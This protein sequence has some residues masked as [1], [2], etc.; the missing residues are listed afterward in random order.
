MTEFRTFRNDDP[1]QILRLWHES[2]LDRGAAANFNTDAFEELIY[3][4]SY[5]D[6]K[7]L[8]LACD[9]KKKVIGFI[10]AGFGP[11]EDSSKLSYDV[12]IVCA[13]IVHPAYRNQGIG[14]ELLH[15]GIEYLKQS[16]TKT[17]LAGPAKPYDP[18]YHGLYGGARPS[19]F[20]ESDRLSALF[21]ESQG[22]EVFS[23]I[24]IYQRDLENSQDPISARLQS[25]RRKMVMQVTEEPDEPNWWWMTRMGRFRTCRFHLV[26]K[27]QDE[28]VGHLTVYEMVFYP[29]KWQHRAIGLLNLF[30]KEEE[31]RKGYGQTL[32]VDVCRHLRQEM[33]T[34]AEI[35]AHEENVAACKTIESAGFQHVDTG[36][37]YRRVHSV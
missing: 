4:Q 21:F 24:R 36:I 20:L 1:P 14:K 29:S 9:E 31:R 17:V 5:F 27:N 22:F 33:I 13:L 2:G 25:I 28:S 19:G 15:R 18:F 35:H 7:G 37:V 3:C 32:L 16:G 11:N 26:P 12:G 6:P 23:K 34:L 10:H 8:I 30:V